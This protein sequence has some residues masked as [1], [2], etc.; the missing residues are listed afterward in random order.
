VPIEV[1][2]D[3]ITRLVRPPAAAAAKKPPPT[4]ASTASCCQ[5][6]HVRLHILGVSSLA[7]AIS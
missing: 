7:G 3:P 2:S 1:A 6:S 5:L 4:A